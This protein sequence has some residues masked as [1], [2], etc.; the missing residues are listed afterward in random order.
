LIAL[1]DDDECDSEQ[2]A[3]IAVETIVGLTG[4]STAL[5]LAGYDVSSFVVGIA[6][7]L[8]FEGISAC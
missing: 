5:D 3:L 4:V 1:N 2:I 8:M 7:E 6:E